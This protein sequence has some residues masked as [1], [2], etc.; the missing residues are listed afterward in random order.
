MANAYLQQYQGEWT[1]VDDD[2]IPGLPGC[3][4]QK[5]EYSQNLLLPRLQA[6]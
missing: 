2:E 4:L 3:F 1:E 6:G 5:R